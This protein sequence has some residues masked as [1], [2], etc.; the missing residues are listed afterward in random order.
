MQLSDQEQRAVA[1]LILRFQIRHSQMRFMLLMA[2]VNMVGVLVV[3]YESYQ[4]RALG[5]VLMILC[6]GAALGG[7]KVWLL[8]SMLSRLCKNIRA[9]K[10]S[11]YNVLN[12]K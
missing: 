1:A 11:L 10:L 9:G 8:D 3:I 4:Y 2:V 5:S 7:Y 12:G 6:F